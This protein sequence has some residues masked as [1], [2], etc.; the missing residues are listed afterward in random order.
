MEDIK[1][2]ENA[3]DIIAEYSSLNEN[4]EVTSTYQYLI[5]EILTFMLDVGYYE[6]IVE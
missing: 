3:I 2:L 4:G 5:D 6:K 1:I